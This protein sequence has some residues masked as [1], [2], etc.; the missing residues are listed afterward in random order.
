MSVVD[1]VNVLIGTAGSGHALVG[2]QMP[3]GMVKSR[4]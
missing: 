3:H 4:P 2:P 1:E